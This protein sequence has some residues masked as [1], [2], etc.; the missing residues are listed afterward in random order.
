MICGGNEA[1]GETLLQAPCQRHWVCTDDVGSFFERAT[2]N[3][4]LYPPKCCG[5]MFLLDLYEAYIPFEVQ[6]AYKMKEQ[7]EYSVLAKY[8]LGDRLSVSI[9]T[10]LGTVSIARTQLAQSFSAPSRM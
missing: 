6:W 1:S 2:E 5:Q 4:S 10:D 3:E 9:L 7:G 8:V